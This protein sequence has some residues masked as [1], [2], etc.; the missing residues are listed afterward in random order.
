MYAKIESK[1]FGSRINEVARTMPDLVKRGDI[2]KVQV[3]FMERNP[4]RKGNGW[5][6]LQL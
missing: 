2:L 6:L 1:V 5:L 3:K 4:V